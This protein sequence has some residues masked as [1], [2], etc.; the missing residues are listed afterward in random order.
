MK[1]QFNLYFLS[2]FSNQPTNSGGGTRRKKDCKNTIGWKIFLTDYLIHTRLV[3]LPPYAHSRYSLSSFC[4]A[5]WVTWGT[6]IRCMHTYTCMHGSC[7]SQLC[8]PMFGG[9]KQTRRISEDGENPLPRKGPCIRAHS[10]LAAGRNFF[11]SSANHQSF[12]YFFFFSACLKQE[13][14]SKD[15]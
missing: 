14:I 7:F 15:E 13:I 3:S 4:L 6:R 12:D 8:K 5:S 1:I 10:H 2:I 9:P 11:H